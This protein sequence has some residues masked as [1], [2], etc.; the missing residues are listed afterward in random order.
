MVTNL[1]EYTAG[2]SFTLGCPQL[3]VIFLQYLVENFCEES[4]LFYMD[5][6]VFRGQKDA[7][8]RRSKADVIYR[9]YIKPGSRHQINIDSDVRSVIESRLK[10]SGTEAQRDLFDDAMCVVYS[11][12]KTDSYPKFL[13]HTSFQAW[14]TA[15]NSN[16]PISFLL[17]TTFHL[18]VLTSSV[19]RRKTKCQSDSE[20]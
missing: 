15:F 20:R 2:L 14:L 7:L 1:Q 19:K 13:K 8:Q 10:E 5:V 16:L 12:L 9:T 18:F 6:T 17:A 11:L 3:C 4:L